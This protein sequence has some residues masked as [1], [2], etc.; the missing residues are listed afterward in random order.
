M[1][2][3][4]VRSFL[5][6]LPDSGFSQKGK[7]CHGGKQ[8]KNRITVAFFVLAAG[9]KEGKPIVIW[10]SEKPRCLKRFNKAE[11]PVNYF[12]QRKAWMTGE[13]LDNVLTRLNRQLSSKNRN[14]LLIM[15]NA[16]CHP[17]E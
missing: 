16:G 12:S 6:S 2:S 5:A 3:R 15:D 14:I 9:K 13:I 4:R 11:L 1:E 7:Q 17:K 8:S 10:K